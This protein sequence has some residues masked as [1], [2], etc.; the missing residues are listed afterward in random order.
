MPDQAG[1]SN[2]AE[3]LSQETAQK[4]NPK[5]ILNHSSSNKMNGWKNS[6][7]QYLASRSPVQ[8]QQQPINPAQ[9]SKTMT[10][11][12]DPNVPGGP[13]EIQALAQNSQ[14]QRQPIANPAGAADNSGKMASASYN[15]PKEAS[16]NKVDPHR[17]A[18]VCALLK[19]AACMKKSKKKKWFGKKADEDPGV[20][21]AAPLAGAGIGA[22]SMAIYNRFLRDFV[23]EGKVDLLKAIRDSGLPLENQLRLF[24]MGSSKLHA[25]GAQPALTA[26]QVGGPIWAGAAAAKHKGGAGRGAAVGTGAGAG[27]GLVAQ[28]AAAL[29]ARGHGG[30][31]IL[32]RI[33][34]A[35]GRGAATGAVLGAIG[36]GIQKHRRTKAHGKAKKEAQLRQ[37]LQKRAGG[38][39]ANAIAATAPTAVKGG[40]GSLLKWLIPAGI[41]TAVAGPP[42]MRY[43]QH[44]LNMALDPM[45][46][47]NYNTQMMM[48]S[49]QMMMMNMMRGY[50]GYGGYGGAPALP[51][52][53]SP[54]DRQMLQHAT[55]LRGLRSR[56]RSTNE[57]F[58]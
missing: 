31:E 21:I 42:L 43:S 54:E 15:P 30:K 35:L 24:R 19:F 16:M 49:P 25:Y 47:Q 12:A 41:A 29:A 46:R 55:Y 7:M 33:P 40:L 5:P 8:S 10:G 4:N 50:G 52:I 17:V 38:A 3:A 32:K 37:V 51:P 26:A 9:T 18:T 14:A 48:N 36:G 44:E 39:A 13:K 11:A 53:M 1:G 20:S 27:I 23:P 6:F 28:L 45:Y 58:D 22:G 34:T 57:A 2:A 56:V